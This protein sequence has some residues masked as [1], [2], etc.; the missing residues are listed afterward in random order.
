MIRALI[1]C[2]GTGE[3]DLFGHADI[4]TPPDG[5]A[6]RVKGL[7]GAAPSSITASVVAPAG[8]PWS[9]NWRPV[10]MVTGAPMSFSGMA[11]AAVSACSEVMPGTTVTCACQSG[12]DA[13]GAVVKRRIAPDQQRHIAGRGMARDG[14]GPDLCDGIVPILDA[15]AIV[16]VGRVRAGHIKFR[17]YCQWV[18]DKCCAD[19][20]AQVGQIGLCLALARDQHQIGGVQRLD[21]L[22]GQVIGIAGAD[23]DQVQ[24]DHAARPQMLEQGHPATTQATSPTARLRAACAAASS[25]GNMPVNSARCGAPMMWGRASSASA[26]SRRQD[27]CA[28][29]Q[30]GQTRHSATRRT[31]PTRPDA[32]PD[33]HPRPR[34]VPGPD[35]LP[36]QAEKAAKPATPHSRPSGPCDGSAELCGQS[37]ILQPKQ[38]HSRSK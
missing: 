6:C 3:D 1:S 29:G 31:A 37:R 34:A 33:R 30:K 24:M 35:P 13:Q 17:L 26:A 20:A 27:A 4:G 10:V 23:A 22:K 32:R 15:P 8:Q 19:L 38:G 36:G 18:S 28:I 9:V 2:Q 7:K 5:N 21:R 16:R 25:G 12:R 14:G 11:W